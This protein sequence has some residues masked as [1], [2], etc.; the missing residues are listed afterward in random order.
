MFAWI[1]ILGNRFRYEIPNP[2]R[3]IVLTTTLFIL[4][5]VLS[6]IAIVLA[7]RIRNPQRSLLRTIFLFAVVFRLV[8]VF[9]TPF[10]EIDSYRY[11]WD[12]I[13]TASGHSPYRFSPYQVLESD[14]ADPELDELR[15]IA[16]RSEAT[17]TIVSRIHYSQV[18]TIYPPVSQLVFGLTAALIPPHAS[19]HTYVIAMKIPIVLFDLGTLLAL[20]FL[21]NR[22]KMHPLWSMVW[23]WN[24]LVIKEFANSGH[25]DSI[26]VFL[27][28]ASLACLVG[29]LQSLQ[30]KDQRVRI[31]AQGNRYFLIASAVLLGLG[32]GAKIYPVI[33]FPLLSSFLIRTSG[34]K[35]A[36]AHTAVFLGVSLTSFAPMAREMNRQRVADDAEKNREGLA[37]F[38][39][40]WQMNELPFMLVYQNLR[41]FDPHQQVDL[42]WFRLLTN[43]QR[44]SINGLLGG[45]VPPAEAPYYMARL[46]TLGIFAGFYLAWLIWIL[47][48]PRQPPR[49]SEPVERTILH[50]C[51]QVLALFF[52]LQ[53]TQNPWYWTWSLVLVPFAR[54]RAWVLYSTFLM[55]YYF[56]FAMINLDGEY[57]FLGYTYTGMGLFDYVIVWIEHIP[58]YV[59]VLIWAFRNKSGQTS[60]PETKPHRSKRRRRKRIP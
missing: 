58:V 12:G 18:R 34:W 5:S 20:V 19:V 26:A 45:R 41:D 24:P 47:R 55:V 60:E 29:F 46:I 33:L 4:A 13:V 44:Q 51:F 36:I 11:I 49:E 40:H 10:Q 39:R 43:R 14:L 6:L 3:P 56:R 30:A 31:P 28:T 42:P 8:Q 38:L 2:E 15:S 17:Y 54:N 22:L 7:L 52:C 27:T 37:T 23:G 50:A 21:L 35:T 32:F 16:L 53:P 48:R 9:A 57:G 25:L 59:C 1:A